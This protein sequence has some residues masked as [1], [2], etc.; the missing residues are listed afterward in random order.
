MLLVYT[1]IYL[2]YNGKSIVTNHENLS[3]DVGNFRGHLGFFSAKSAG[4]NLGSFETDLGNFDRILEIFLVE[5]F[6]EN[7]R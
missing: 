3:Q 4:K 6:G 7:T 5:K 2:D 1:V